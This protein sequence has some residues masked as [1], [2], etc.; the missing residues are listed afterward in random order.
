MVVDYL[1]SHNNFGMHIEISAEESLLDT[2]G[3]L[4]KAAPFFLENGSAP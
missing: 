1:D 4:K 2:G 3:G